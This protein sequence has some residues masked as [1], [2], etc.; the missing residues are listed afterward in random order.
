MTHHAKILAVRRRDWQWILF[1]GSVK[2]AGNIQ[3]GVR[4]RLCLKSWMRFVSLRRQDVGF[5]QG[6]AGGVGFASHNGR[7]IT[8]R[9][10]DD[11][12]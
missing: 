2:E 6:V 1:T 4:Q 9:T 12:G 5:D 7:G 3:A 10:H 11:D 8:G